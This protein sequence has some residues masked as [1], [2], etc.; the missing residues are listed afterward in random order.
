[1]LKKE[2]RERKYLFHEKKIIY[3][4]NL[5]N[6]IVI[7]S[8]AKFLCLDQEH[9]IQNEMIHLVQQLHPGIKSDCEF[10]YYFDRIFYFISLTCSFFK[11][12]TLKFPNSVEKFSTFKT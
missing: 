6:I 4:S 10:I 11:K 8:M 2:K 7:L 9:K 5:P 12:K 1:M 3:Q